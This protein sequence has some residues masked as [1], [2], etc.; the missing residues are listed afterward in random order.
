MPFQA[1]VQRIRFLEIFRLNR[2]LD[3]YM[4]A[5]YETSR[6][7]NIVLP[8]YASF[9]GGLMLLGVYAHY[10]APIEVKNDPR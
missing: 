8:I 3:V 10:A 1:A 9:I 7:G 4:G 2:R 5:V 6:L